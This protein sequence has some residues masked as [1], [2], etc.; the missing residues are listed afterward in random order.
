MSKTKI[1]V[2]LKEDQYSIHLVDNILD[3]SLIKKYISDRQIMIIYDNNLSIEKVRDFSSMINSYTKFETISMGIVATED[4]KSQETLND[5][6]NRLIEEKFSR[7]CLLIGMGGGIVCDISGFAAATYLRGVDFVLIPTSLLAQVDASVGGKTAINHAL[8]KNL[9]G[10]FHQPSV[11]VSDP[12]VL[13]TLPRR[14][15]RSGLYEVVKYGMIRDPDLFRRLQNHSSD[16]FSLEPTELV[17]II[18]ASCRIK[19]SVVSEDEYEGNIRRI[20]N[21]GHTAGH[22]IEAATR[23]RRFRH[24]EAIAYGML[25]VADLAV[26][27]SLLK[28]DDQEALAQLI[29][30]LGPLP[31][32]SDLSAKS[33]IEIMGRDKKVLKG[34]LHVILPTSIGKTVIVDDITPKELKQS[35]RVV[36]TAG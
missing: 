25:V 27:R 35:L 2:K 19:A 33:L 30:Q 9:I 22:A 34:R 13:S 4:K 8:G 18:A 26:R 14:E 23:Y 36:G 15:F 31:S 21:F 24:G 28:K 7:D 10:A 32:I 6:H 20:L 5:I 29:T 11:V 12:V 1:N 17:R 16:I 3:P